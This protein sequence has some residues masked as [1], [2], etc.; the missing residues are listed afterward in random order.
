MTLSLHSVSS[1]HGSKRGKKRVGR[2]LGSKGTTAGRGQKGQSSRAGSHGLTRIGMRHQMLQ[3]PKLRGFTSQYKKDYPLNIGALASK[4]VN[5]EVVTPAT[6]LKKGI[7]PSGTKTVKILGVG[8]IKIAL[9][10]KGCFVS[11]SAKEKITAAGGTV[12]A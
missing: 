12:A 11:A 2:G 3:T 10:V 4:C 1:A 7:V 9:T 5:G 8:D 6:L